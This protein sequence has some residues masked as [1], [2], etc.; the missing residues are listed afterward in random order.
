MCGLR[1]GLRTI[2]LLAFVALGVVKTKQTGE[3]K[4]KNNILENI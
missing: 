1:Q 3:S 4:N 2:V